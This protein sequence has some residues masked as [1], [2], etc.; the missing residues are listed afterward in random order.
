MTES[1]S[2]VKSLKLEIW[3][4][5]RKG[6]M[7]SSGGFHKEFI[8]YDHRGHRFQSIRVMCQHYKISDFTFRMRRKKGWS[9]EDALTKPVMKLKRKA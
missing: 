9:V 8:V 6:L 2:P 1:E 7:H 5:D 4:N 3:L